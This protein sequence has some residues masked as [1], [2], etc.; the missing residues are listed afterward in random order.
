VFIYLAPVSLQTALARPH[1][2]HLCS[3]VSAWILRA[4]RSRALH[5]NIKC[6]N[7]LFPYSLKSSYPLN[8]GSNEFLKSPVESI[9]QVKLCNLETANNTAKVGWTRQ[10]WTHCEGEKMRVWTHPKT[11]SSPYFTG[12]LVGAQCSSWPVENM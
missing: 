12:S 3:N 11:T 2:F 4:G 7:K 8:S 5:T 1:V 6:V 10:Y 9:R